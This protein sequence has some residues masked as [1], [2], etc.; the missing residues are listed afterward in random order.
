MALKSDGTVVEWGALWNGRAPTGLTGVVAIARGTDHALALKSNGTVVA[1]GHNAQGQTMC[2]LFLR[3]SWESPQRL[4]IVCPGSRMAPL[5]LGEDNRRFQWLERIIAINASSI[6]ASL[7]SR[8]MAL[9]S[10]GASRAHLKDSAMSWPW[11]RAESPSG[12]QIRRHGRG[13]G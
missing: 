13:L 1:W 10:P 7:R 3:M 11:R 12:A 6:G 2:L 4:H 8:R 5:L 9:W